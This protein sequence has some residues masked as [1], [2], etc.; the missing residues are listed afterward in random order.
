MEQMVLYRL[1]GT[2]I[3]I[4]LLNS[5]DAKQAEKII[6][7]RQKLWKNEQFNPDSLSASFENDSLFTFCDVLGLFDGAELDAFVILRYPHKLGWHLRTAITEMNMTLKRDSRK[8]TPAGWD[9]NNT[10][11]ITKMIEYLESVHLFNHWT[12]MSEA[13][14]AHRDNPDFEI[15]QRYDRE[16]VEAIPA[17][18]RAVGAD[19]EFINNFLVQREFAED[20]S[21]RYSSLRS[22]FRPENGRLR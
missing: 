8:K 14:T 11:L 5:L 4:R 2:D 9:E 20:I 19:A 1:P 7:S 3:S 12:V 13:F 15:I 16:I 22:E 18:K 10:F 6:R 17:G 21:V